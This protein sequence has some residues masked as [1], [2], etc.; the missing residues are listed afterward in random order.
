MEDKPQIIREV[1]EGDEL[2][3]YEAVK[4][5]KKLGGTAYVSIPV[6]LLNK[7]VKIIYKKE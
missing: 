4:I 7:R 5:A 1:T 2:I 3:I 6:S